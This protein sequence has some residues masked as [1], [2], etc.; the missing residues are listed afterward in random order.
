MPAGHAPPRQTINDLIFISSSILIKLKPFSFIILLP[1]RVIPIC[2][3]NKLFLNLL[4]ANN[5]LQIIVAA[6]NI[7]F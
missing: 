5:K 3:L 6:Y 2:I 1:M 7:Y 4:F